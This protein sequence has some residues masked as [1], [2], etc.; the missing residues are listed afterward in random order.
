MKPHMSCLAALALL[1]A[2]PVLAEGFYIGAEAQQIRSYS[3]DDF[4]EGSG[5]CDVEPTGYRVLLGYAFSPAFAIEA[6]YMDG[7]DSEAGYSDGI[8]SERITVNSE[9]A[10]VSVIGRLPLSDSFS[11]FGRFGA[12]RIVNNTDFSFSDSIDEFSAS[13]DNDVTTYVYGVGIQFGWLVAGY[14]VY[15]ENSLEI[16][17]ETLAEEDLERIYAGLKIGF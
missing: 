13:F 16:D 2:G 15:S 10:D 8:F 7:G 4:C 9:V 3:E 5:D 1:A 12:A 6:G 11:L 14:D 17:G